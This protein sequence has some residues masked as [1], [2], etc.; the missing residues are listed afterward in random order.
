MRKSTASQNR[1]VNLKFLQHFVRDRDRCTLRRPKPPDAWKCPATPSLCNN[2][3]KVE[4][5]TGCNWSRQTFFESKR[6]WEIS[7]RVRARLS[8]AADLTLVSYDLGRRRHC[9]ENACSPSAIR[10]KTSIGG[11]PCGGQTAERSKTSHTP[12]DLARA[13]QPLSWLP[14][15][16]QSRKMICPFTPR[17]IY[18]S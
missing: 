16:I 15:Y 3:D 10:C 11:E 8:R 18:P 5:A 6:P 2:T 9:V 4:G 1:G 13:M 17:S 7:T 12:W 14:G